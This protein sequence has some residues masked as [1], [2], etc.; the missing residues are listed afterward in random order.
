MRFLADENLER[1]VAV[2]LQSLSHDVSIIGVDHPI[3]L[4]DEE[5][6]RI[7]HREQR[8]LI[9]SDRDFGELIFRER[10]PHAGVIYFRLRLDA[11]ADEKIERLKDLFTRHDNLAGRYFVV[12]QRRI[13]A[14]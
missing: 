2:F 8:I 14:R 3:S 12:E 9:T 1:R 6:L 11:S 10:L 13:R 5:V 7:A 4:S